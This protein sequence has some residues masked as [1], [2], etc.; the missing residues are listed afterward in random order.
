M[1]NRMFWSEIGSRGFQEAKFWGS[2]P[3]EVNR[4]SNFD[5]NK[6]RVFLCN[7]LPHYLKEI[8]SIGTFKTAL[9]ECYASEVL[10]YQSP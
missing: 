8:A 1:K 7:S 4:K 5:E 9:S 2:T 3:G 10:S 6:Y